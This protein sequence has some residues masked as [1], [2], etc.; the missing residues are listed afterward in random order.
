MEVPAKV[1]KIKISIDSSGVIDREFLKKEKQSILNFSQVV[2]DMN[3]KFLPVVNLYKNLLC[4]KN[5][6][7]TYRIT[8]FPLKMSK[9]SNGRGEPNFWATPFRFCENSYFSKF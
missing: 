2:W 5:K 3:T 1:I 8:G 4:T 7:K 6:G 9:I